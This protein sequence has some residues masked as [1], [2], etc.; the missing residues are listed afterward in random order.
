MVAGY[1][2]EYGNN[3]TFATV[4]ASV[5]IGAGHTAP[6]YKPKESFS[7]FKRWISQQP[8][9]ILKA[10][11]WR[12]DSNI[13]THCNITGFRMLVIVFQ[14]HGGGTVGDVEFFYYFIQSESNPSKDPLI[15]WLTGGPGFETGD[16]LFA[17]DGYN[18]V[19]KASK[20]V[21]I[22]AQAIS[23]GKNALIRF[24][25]GALSVVSNGTNVTQSLQGYLVGNPAT[26][27]KYD[28]NSKI[29]FYNR[30]ALISDEFYNQPKGIVKEENVEAD[31]SV[32][33]ILKL[34]QRKASKVRDML[35]TF[36]ARVAK[37]EGSMSDVRETLEEVKGHTTEL[38]SRQY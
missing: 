28:D 23:D 3:F 14:V 38:E 20:I 8:L 29:P 24:K 25:L 22:I 37:L 32:Q 34:S 11:L 30:M 17:N 7:M 12:D 6:E 31:M 35:S 1:S 26:G 10:A 21:P 9:V 19:R 18:F 2:R 16:K 36:K 27:S 15:L 4:K 5:L 13:E 33:K